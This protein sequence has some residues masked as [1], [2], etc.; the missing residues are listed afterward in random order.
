MKIFKYVLSLSESQF[1]SMPID[2]QILSVG[3]QNREIVIWAKVDPSMLTAAKHFLIYG[4]GW[5]LDNLD[6][7]KY[8]GTVQ[9]D[10]FVWHV[11]VENRTY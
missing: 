1:V 10:R 6:A 7:Y 2:S 11:F 3:V 8:L 9:I 5:D 4:T